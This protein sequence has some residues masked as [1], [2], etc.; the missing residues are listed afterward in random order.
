[1]RKKWI[2]LQPWLD[3]FEMLQT[4]VEKAYL[5]MYPDKNVAYITEAALLTLSNADK[6]P[7]EDKLKQLRAYMTVM[8]RIHAYAAWQ[9]RQ[10][11]RYLRK[12]FALHV[13][14]DEKP[15]DMVCTILLTRVRRWY[16]PFVK[17]ENIDVIPYAK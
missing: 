5:E 4:Y 16:W 9:A 7:K 13:V 8:R 15:H 11:Y 10:G 6:I 1:M 2:N 14:K 17:R 3:Y 12:P